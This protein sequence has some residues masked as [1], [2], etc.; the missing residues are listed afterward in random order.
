MPY[1]NIIKLIFSAHKVIKYNNLSLL[2][3]RNMHAYLCVVLCRN[4]ES[5]L[6]HHHDV[7]MWLWCE[8]FKQ[9]MI[10]FIFLDIG[11][12]IDDNKSS[13]CFTLRWAHI[14]LCIN[15]LTIAIYKSCATDNYFQI[16]HVYISRTIE[17]HYNTIRKIKIT[18]GV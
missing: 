8:R 5:C 3:I 11:P 10:S 14:A 12:I 2:K 17:K 9:Q 15:I 16:K 6:A 13:L 7:N 18:L 1:L 4:N